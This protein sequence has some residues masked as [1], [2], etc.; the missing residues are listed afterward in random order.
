MASI[1]ILALA[2][3][4]LQRC[5]VAT[6]VVICK[7]VAYQRMYTRIHLHE[8]TCLLGIMPLVARPDKLED[9]IGGRAPDIWSACTRE[10]QEMPKSVLTLARFFVIE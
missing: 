4:V 7:T 1:Y 3:V 5:F 10:S 6:F 8:S 2:G 9:I